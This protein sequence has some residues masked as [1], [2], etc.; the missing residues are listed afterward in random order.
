MSFPS[1]AMYIENSFLLADD[2]TTL[3][4]GRRA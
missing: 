3:G 1:V 4:A 2:T